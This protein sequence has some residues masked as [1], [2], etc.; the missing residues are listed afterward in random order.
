MRSRLLFACSILFG[1][2]VGGTAVAQQEAVTSKNVNLRAGPSRDYPL[3]AQIPEGSSV[4]VV[5]CQENYAWCD[6]VTGPDRGWVYSGNLEY[7]YEGQAVP[8]LQEGPV[9]GFP[10]VSFSVGPYWDNYYRGRPWYARRSYFA[11]R[12]LPQP[13]AWVRPT[14]SVSVQ[15]SGQRASYA[16]RTGSQRTVTR[17]QPDVRQ[18]DV[19]HAQ[20]RHVEQRPQNH[21]QA[22]QQPNRQ[23]QQQQAQQQ[24]QQHQQ[25]QRPQDAHSGH[26]HEDK[27]H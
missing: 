17:S 6:V 8:I 26:D 10:I 1:T 18:R 12:P 20:E 21:S 19:N 23:R 9:I 4:Q 11:A 13:G 27:K 14:R 16:N 25:H 3:V 5:G 24:P 15:S 2:L 22:Q 7:P